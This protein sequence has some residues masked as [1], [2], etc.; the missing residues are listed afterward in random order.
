MSNAILVSHGIFEDESDWRVHVAFGAGVLYLFPTRSARRA[1][2]ATWLRER[3]ATQPGARGPTA[4]GFAVPW[5]TIDGIVELK[6]PDS[7][8]ADHWVEHC[9]PVEKKGRAAVEVVKEML[10]SGR[11]RLP[12]RMEHEEI[13]AWE[14]QVRGF[15]LIL[16]RTITLQIKCDYYAGRGGTGNLYLQTRER[17]PFGKR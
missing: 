14:M 6:I 15:D 3:E 5:Q 13:D 10:R 1:L 17:N 11:L 8:L 7:I 4:A 2:E 12:T 9:E 16:K